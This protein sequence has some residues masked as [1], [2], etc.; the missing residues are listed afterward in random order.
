MDLKVGD[1]MLNP[2]TNKYYTVK[3]IDGN[4]IRFVPCSEEN[5]GDKES[6]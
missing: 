4:T 3:E 1:K 6:D 5:V 2:T